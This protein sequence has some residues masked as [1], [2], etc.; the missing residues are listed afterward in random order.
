MPFEFHLTVGGGEVQVESQPISLA[1]GSA[2]YTHMLS[3]L[4][5]VLQYS[6]IK[7]CH[8]DSVSS[9]ISLPSSGFI[10]RL[11]GIRKKAAVSP[12]IHS[13]S[14]LAWKVKIIFS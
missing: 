1:A 3:K 10:L 9:S 5:E 14:G 6:V 2:R 12:H 13:G 11:P 8:L 4:D 7:L